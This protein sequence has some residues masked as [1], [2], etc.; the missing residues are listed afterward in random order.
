MIV[1]VLR[2]PYVPDGFS[3]HEISFEFDQDG[4]AAARGLSIEIFDTLLEARVLIEQ[5]RMEYNHLR[6]DS[7]L[8]YRPPAPEAVELPL[9]YAPPTGKGCSRRTELKSGTKP[10]AGHL[11]LRRRDDP[12]LSNV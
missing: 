1:R 12:V 7:S 3:H 2:N 4:R 8:G 9:G 5:S 6:P 11:A 10:G